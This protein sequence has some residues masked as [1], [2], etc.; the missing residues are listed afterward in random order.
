MKKYGFLLIRLHELKNHLLG[1][2]KNGI[3]NLYIFEL[4]NTK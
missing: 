1:K 2:M 3:K 4:A